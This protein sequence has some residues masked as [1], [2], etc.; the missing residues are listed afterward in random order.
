MPFVPKDQGAPAPDDDTSPW[1]ISVSP[2]GNSEFD[3]KVQ[4]GK[5]LLLNSEP[6]KFVT[7]VFVTYDPGH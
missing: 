7:N 6:C 5:T 1:G 4:I 3:L 2:D